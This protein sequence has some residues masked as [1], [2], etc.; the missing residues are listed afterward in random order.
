[1]LENIKIIAIEEHINLKNLNKEISKYYNEDS[2]NAK[3]ASGKNLPYYPDF[4][5]Y[6]EEGINKRLADMNKNGISKQILSSPQQTQILNPNNAS[7]IVKEAN[8]DLFN[9]ISNHKDRF[10]AF[11]LLPWSNINEAIDE[12]KRLKYE[13]NFEGVI[14]AGRPSM[15]AI[16]LDDKR[17]YPILETLEKLNMP[18]Y[19]HPAPPLKCVQKNY[20]NGLDEKLSARLSLYGWGWHNEVGIQIIRMIVSGVFEKFPNLKIITGHWGEMV[21]FFLSRL[22]QALPLSVTKNK[23]SITETFKKN[24][25]ITPSGIFDY[26]QLKFCI[27]VL[28]ADHIIFSVDFPFIANENAKKFI[29][30]S[31]ISDNEKELISYKNA[32][33]L[34][35]G[36]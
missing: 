29:L 14:L 28:G 26:P 10:G 24:I 31:P 17:Y 6:S 36:K 22:D 1:M 18:L 2:E 4:D 20:Y 30:D 35:Y 12:I 5:L 34:F 3:A 16:F 27:D 25:Y 32:Y 21:P 33:N 23:T 11:G 7:K 13:L 9:I 15:E 8:D 19:L